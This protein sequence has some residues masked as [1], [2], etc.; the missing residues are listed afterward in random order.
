MHQDVDTAMGTRE[1]L[2]RSYIGTDDNHERI[3]TLL[4]GM[5]KK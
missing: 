1:W 4:P 2:F 3:D 5:K